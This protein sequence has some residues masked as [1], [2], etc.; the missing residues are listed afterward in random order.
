[1]ARQTSDDFEVFFVDYGSWP[2]TAEKVKKLC[3]A[4]PFI[5]YQYCF[6]QFQPWNK[7]RALNSVIKTLDSGFCFVADVDMIFHSQFVTQAIALQKP[8]TTTYF[9]VGFTSKKDDISQI[10][11]EK[12]SDFRKSTME[13]TGLSIFPVEVLKE[14]HGF[15]ICI[16]N[17]NHV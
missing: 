17:H 11:E 12:F 10:S 2:E 1:L 8:E 16:A 9:Q 14:L 4:Y 3:A 5:T 7:S 15:D 13:A 6:T